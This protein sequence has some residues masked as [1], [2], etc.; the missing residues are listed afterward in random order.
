MIKAL[1]H[2]YPCNNIIEENDANIVV[3]STDAPISQLLALMSPYM[4]HAPMCSII[5]CILMDNDHSNALE[6]INY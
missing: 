3:R 5:S 4:Y 1:V 2:I 6:H